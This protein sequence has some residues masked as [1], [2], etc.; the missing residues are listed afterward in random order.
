MPAETDSTPPRLVIIIVSCVVH[1][2]SSLYICHTSF[3]EPH[4]F[5][6]RSIPEFGSSSFFI[7]TPA[8]L[9]PIIS[10]RPFS[11]VSGSFADNPSKSSPGHEV[12]PLPAFAGVIL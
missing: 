12:N 8:L 2:V 10:H 11:F 4:D 5:S 9:S 7:V 1:P 3:V 6:A